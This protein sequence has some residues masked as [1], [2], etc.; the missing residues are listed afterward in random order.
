MTFANI[1]A[2]HKMK[3]HALP[4]SSMM[5]V[6]HWVSVRLRVQTRASMGMLLYA[7]GSKAPVLGKRKLTNHV[8][9]RLAVAGV[10]SH[11]PQ[12]QVLSRLSLLRKVV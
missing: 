3:F 1:H 2:A 8:T 9:D 10:E 11:D 7:I 12:L 5:A 4:R 6:E